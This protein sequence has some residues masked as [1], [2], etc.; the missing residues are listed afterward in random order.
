MRDSIL[1]SALPMPSSGP[2]VAW[3]RRMIEEFSCL[4]QAHIPFFL[5][6]PSAHVKFDNVDLGDVNVSCALFLPKADGRRKYATTLAG[7]EQR[8]G[9]RAILS[10]GGVSEHA[11]LSFICRNGFESIFIPS[12]ERASNFSR[13][14]KTS[15]VTWEN[16]RFVDIF[17]D[18]RAVIERTL[19]AIILL[20]SATPELRDAVNACDFKVFIEELRYIQ[21][22]KLK[23]GCRRYDLAEGILIN[24]ACMKNYEILF[25]AAAS[26]RCLIKSLLGV[27]Q[28]GT[29]LSLFQPHADC[30][31]TPF[32]YFNDYNALDACLRI[33]RQ[34]TE[35]VH[36]YGE[37][38]APKQ[39]LHVDAAPDT[40]TRDSTRSLSKQAKLAMWY[41]ELS[42]NN[43]AGVFCNMCGKK[44]DFNDFAVDHVFPWSKGGKTEP[45]NLQV[46]CKACNQKKGARIDREGY[47]K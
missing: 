28:W 34:Y 29:V 46:L 13:E 30:A 35:L 21:R 5:L 38:F 36:F 42:K 7:K 2:T 11:E 18:T 17:F 14:R 4:M 25:Y 22:T 32:F 39:L 23:K 27:S 47:K 26:V 45:S 1:F 44:L 24:L 19:S 31:E 10:E 41:A 3:T 33:M 40:H 6:A 16:G 8:I 15:V 9:A 37:D 43:G 20:E 12:K